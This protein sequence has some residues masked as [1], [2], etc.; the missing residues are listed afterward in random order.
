M[1]G[2]ANRAACLHALAQI[3]PRVLHGDR[4][5]QALR[6]SCSAKHRAQGP[7]ELESGPFIQITIFSY[8]FALNLIFLFQWREHFSDSSHSKISQSQEQHWVFS[9]GLWSGSGSPGF[10]PSSYFSAPMDFTSRPGSLPTLPG[11]L[12][13]TLR[14]F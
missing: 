4:Q 6:S 3:S 2:F 14:A 13:R 1:N 8:F 10:R 12:L 7:Q 11:L 5:A 9:W